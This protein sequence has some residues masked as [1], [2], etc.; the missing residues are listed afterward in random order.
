M[1]AFTDDPTGAPFPQARLTEFRSPSPAEL[2][3]FGSMAG[4][5][6]SVARHRTIRREGDRPQC[7]YMLVEGW[8]MSC[9]TLADGRRQIVKVHLPGDMLGSPSIALDR[10]AETLIALTPVKLRSIGFTALGSLFTRA[11]HMAA[12]L[13]L[14]AQ[15]ERVILM[16]RLCSIGRTS[17]ECRLSALLVHL[18]DRLNLIRP[19][20][21]RRFDH[22]LTQEQIGDIIGL[23]SV[24]VNRVF[25]ALE[26]KKLILRDGHSI[27]LLDIPALRRLSGVPERMLAQD[28]S[29]L[30]K[31][32]N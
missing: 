4:P 24:H 15:Q 32:L 31:P 23:T 30:P 7:V 26:D 3:I 17:A 9:M 21:G 28:L 6:Q 27:E 29:W 19:E 5:I 13:F 1:R 20:T 16:D 8:V 11:P 25:R 10:A 12:L 2:E 14:S 22:P 18:H